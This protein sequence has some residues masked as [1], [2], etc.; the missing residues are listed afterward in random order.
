[1]INLILCDTLLNKGRPEISVM[2]ISTLRNL[3]TIAEKE[4]EPIRYIY[5]NAGIDE[6][7]CRAC[8]KLLASRHNSSTLLIGSQVGHET[9]GMLASTSFPMMLDINL[10]LKTR[11]LPEGI[12]KCSELG[13][14]LPIPSA[15]S[16]TH[17]LE[18]CLDKL[19][20]IGIK[21]ACLGVGWSNHYDG[22]V[23][24]DKSEYNIWAHKLLSISAMLTSRR[25]L[26]SMACGLPLCLLSKDQLSLMTTMRVRWPIAIC[27]NQ[28]LTV[29]PKGETFLCPK[30]RHRF[31]MNLFEGGSLIGIRNTFN[32]I[33]MP[34]SGL[35]L[36]SANPCRSLLTRACPGE[37][38]AYS[39]SQW[40]R[41]RF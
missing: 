23:I 4:K 7:H 41:Y 16:D 13:L 20:G 11:S 10:F 38:L 21:H 27:Y 19:T 5:I 8:L 12:E 17:S 34:F 39:L 35:C 24:I 2:D 18:E 14:F 22:P 36:K 9:V 29:G 30:T 32:Q 28:E 37:C 31:M 3:L 33:I 40:Q 15:D 6:G 1:M 26:F 25:I